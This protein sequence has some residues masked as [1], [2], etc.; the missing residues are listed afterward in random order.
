MVQSQ[1]Q[2]HALTRHVDPLRGRD[3]G[4]GSASAP[5]RSITYALSQVAAGDTLQ[6]V[7]GTYSDE[8]FPIRLPAGVTLL[9]NGQRQGE[10]IV[11]RGGGRY[12]S[13]TFGAQ[14]VA[15]VLADRSMLRGVTVTNPEPNGTGAWVESTAPTIQDC[16][17]QGCRREGMFA[18]GNS[19]PLVVNCLFERNDASGIFL[20]RQAKGELRQ[21]LCRN[22]G[23]GIAISDS[24]APL[25]IDNRL[26]GN[27]SGIVLSRT[28]RPVLRN[29]HVQRSQADGLTVLDQA[30]PDLGDTQSAGG[31]TF[32]GS[33]RFDVHNTSTSVLVSAGNQLNPA[34]ASGS[35]IFRPLDLPP[36]V[37]AVMV[38]PPPPTLE[39]DPRPLLPFPDIAGSWAP[40]FIVALV[41][42]NVIRGFPDGT[43]RPTASLTRVQLAVLLTQAFN[44]P[45]QRLAQSFSD[46]S[47]DFWGHSAIQQAT[48]TGFIAG[49]P[50]GTFRPNTALTRLQTMLAL[51]SGLRLASGTLDTLALYRDRAE[52]PSWATAAVAAVTQN[53]IVVNYPRPELLEPLRPV[54]RAE[55]SAMIYQ[56]LV[57]RGAASPI[58]SPF[59]VAP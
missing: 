18:L 10:G 40:A 28:C 34:R 29:N 39:P 7:V 48:R 49:F 38:A 44:S 31:N 21:N 35:V 42:R 5:F 26:E 27:R 3:R 23:F 6:L 19:R 16:R 8:T 32:D 37:S 12:N 11:I 1:A 9:G 55:I 30:K 54:S 25:V 57:S 52:I 20:M 47:P 43:F 50:D 56:G 58:H 41:D 45:A 51:H 4:A 59:I 13:P 17:F 53:R 36:P 24:A 33:G 14:S 46:V 15:I 2:A 22:T